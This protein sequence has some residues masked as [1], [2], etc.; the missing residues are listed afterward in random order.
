ML[1]RY[2]REPKTKKPRGVLVALSDP[3]KNPDEFMVGY[4]LCH[5]LDKFSKTKALSLATSRAFWW[6]KIKR[7]LP[8]VPSSV[9]PELASF[10]NRCQRYFKDMGVPKW[11]SLLE[12]EIEWTAGFDNSD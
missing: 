3:N 4:S 2:I 6:S 9:R 11:V 5:K 10:L 12:D 1:V 7:R 8:N